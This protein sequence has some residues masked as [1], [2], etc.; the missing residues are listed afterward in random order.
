MKMIRH[1]NIA[2]N[3]YIG[4]CCL[5]LQDGAL[6]TGTD[7]GKNYFRRDGGIPPYS[8]MG[9][10]LNTRK[11]TGTSASAHCDEIR[12]RCAVIIVFQPVPLAGGKIR[13]HSL[14]PQ[15]LIQLLKK[16]LHLLGGANGNAQIIGKAR[17][18]E[19]A[20]QHAFLP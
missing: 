1:N 11:N 17:C 16:A 13:A 2:V 4:I 12:S 3:G 10:A 9:S 7:R 19:I 15:Y 8:T 18:I 14:L 20:D 5:C 6:Q